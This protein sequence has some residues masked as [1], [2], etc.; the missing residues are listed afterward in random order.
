MNII[1]TAIR[2]RCFGPPDPLLQNSEAG[3][4]MCLA[5]HRTGAQLKNE[6][7]SV[8]LPLASTASWPQPLNGEKIADQDSDTKPHQHSQPCHYTLELV[9]FFMLEVPCS[10]LC[11]HCC[12]LHKHSYRG[13]YLCFKE[14]AF[15]ASCLADDVAMPVL[16][17]SNLRHLVDVD[18][19]MNGL[20][21]DVLKQEALHK[22]QPMRQAVQTATGVARALLDRNQ[23]RWVDLSL[24]FSSKAGHVS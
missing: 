19:A 11:K 4:R 1:V 5:C 24:Y 21:S 17:L 12:Q 6:M 22:V 13:H 18:A 10:I 16:Q 20:H 8:R 3:P 2:S 15:G 9:V 23:F 14:T 7:G